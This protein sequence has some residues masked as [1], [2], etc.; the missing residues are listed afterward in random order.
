M[1]KTEHVH[2]LIVVAA[3]GG[4]LA[5]VIANKRNAMMDPGADITQAKT[6]S[7]ATAFNLPAY[8]RYNRA[9]WGDVLEPFLPGST[10]GV[11]TADTSGE[12]YGSYYT[13]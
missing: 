11:N 10:T 7:P 3:I 13:Q 5:L 8:V 9:A 4:A 2:F 6:M 1:M 12:Q